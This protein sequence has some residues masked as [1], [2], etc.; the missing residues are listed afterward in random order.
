MS[1]FLPTVKTTSDALCNGDLPYL[2][3]G[4]WVEIEHGTRGQYVGHTGLTVWMHWHRGDKLPMANNLFSLKAA[5]FDRFMD[6]KN[7]PIIIEMPDTMGCWEAH[8]QAS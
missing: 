1:S 2:K 4:Q 7:K 3:R 5:A 6:K 8:Q